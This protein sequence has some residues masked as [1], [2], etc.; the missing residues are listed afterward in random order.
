MSEKPYIS[1]KEQAQLTQKKIFDTTLVLIRKKGYQ[2]VTIREICQNTQISIGTFYLYF[3]S[4]DDILLET[5]NKLDYKVTAPELSDSYSVSNW[6]CDYFRIYLETLIS[7][8]DK[9]LLREICR[10]HLTS[11]NNEFLS[12]DRPMIQN[13]TAILEKEQYRLLSDESPYILCQ[14]IHMF[15][16]SYLFHWLSDNNIEN[17]FLTETSINDLKNF[18]TLYI[19]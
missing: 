9:S 15:M 3:S 17:C 2:K 12:K 18:L 16:Q 14:K 4:K 7:T 10:I 5:F 1:R 8:F 11:G 13:I 6:I 19:S